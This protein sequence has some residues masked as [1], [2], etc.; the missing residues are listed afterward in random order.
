MAILGP[1]NRVTVA[2]DLLAQRPFS[3]I[4]QIS[5][6]FPDQA[7]FTGS[8]AMIG[9]DDVLTAGHLIYAEDHGGW[10][11]T[12]I[13]APALSPGHPPFGYLTTENMISVEGWVAYQ[14]FAW[15]Y[16][17]LDL[18]DNIG[19]QTGWFDIESNAGTG[20]MVES[21]GYPEDHGSELMV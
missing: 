15:D 16:A 17:Y 3:A 6:R 8:G 7:W 10:A 13:V 9:P 12:A 18:S 1:D 5:V 14:D 2:E 11:Y 19:F 20:S 21:L 4:V